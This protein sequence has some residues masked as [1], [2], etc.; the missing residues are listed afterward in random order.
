M[1]FFLR[2]RGPQLE[3]SRVFHA[4]NTVCCLYPV[5]LHILLPKAG[6]IQLKL[7]V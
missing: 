2:K 5:I 4:Y 6:F 1:L 7:P 3:F